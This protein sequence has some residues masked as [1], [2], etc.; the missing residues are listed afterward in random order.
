MA[1]LSADQRS[2]A[3]AYDRAAGFLWPRSCAAPKNQTKNQWYNQY[4][5]HRVFPLPSFFFIRSKT[6]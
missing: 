2:G 6:L 1:E 3:R 5:L 4:F